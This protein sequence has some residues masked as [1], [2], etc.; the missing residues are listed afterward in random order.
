MEHNSIKRQRRIGALA[1]C[2][3]IAA[4]SCSKGEQA[5]A[6]QT[7]TASNAAPADQSA[8]QG[9]GAP[10][11]TASAPVTQASWSPDAL[12]E[13]VAPIALY[14][15]ALVGQIL[16]ASINSQEV[17]DAGNWLLENQNLK[18][19]DLDKAA[20]AIGLGPAM[21][22]LVHFPTIVDMMCQQLDW[23]K[24]L[25]SAF[26]SDQKSVLDA[27]QRLRAQAKE[28]GNL[29]TTPQQ[30]VE[31]KTE[32][33]NT[34]IEVKPAEPTV[35]Y[36][37][38][39]NPQTVYTQPAPA[40]TTTTTTTTSSDDNSDE[41]AAGVIGFGLGVLLGSA[42]DDDDDCY[43]HWGYGGVYY[44]GAP[45]Y[46]PAYAYR[47]AYG[48]G[49]NRVNHYNRNTN[50][51]INNNNNYFN[52]FE[53]NKNLRA[54]NTRVNNQRGQSTYA[55]AG[56][57]ANQGAGAQN[58]AGSTG[59]NGAQNRAGSSGYN[60]AQNRAGSTGYNGAQNRSS[61]AYNGAQANRADRGYGDSG[62]GSRAS[63]S[64]Q[65]RPASTAQNR[66][67]AS[68]SR[69]SAQTSQASSQ[70]R[71]SS[72]VGGASKSSG[73]F[74]RSAS[75]RG[76]SSQAASRSGGGGRSAGGGGRRG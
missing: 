74:D 2:L 1:A 57:R 7:P 15:D 62:A 68:Q 42:L 41:L 4:T 52:R 73:S 49:Y 23:T 51:N 67:A 29:K 56:Q 26:S 3:L 70:R 50:I 19:A 76:R 12:D 9:A 40:Q 45:F 13:L 66:P 37:P 59:Y 60:G 5:G 46:P 39:Y 75:A 30:T 44:G 43:P 20:E 47:P 54:S 27:V 32:G 21:R 35:V 64:A 34:Y 22:S 61:Q 72:A 53:N 16:A 11:S 58:R 55:G 6:Q 24:Q 25:G 28:V 48:N 36:V 65:N 10:A 17:L 69:P 8:Q 31:T 38:Q 14:P 33:G 71:D 63:S 18:G